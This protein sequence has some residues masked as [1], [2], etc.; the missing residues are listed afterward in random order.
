MKLTF[1]PFFKLEYAFLSFTGVKGTV[2]SEPRA[3]RDALV[4]VKS[5]IESVAFAVL[6]CVFF[7]V[8]VRM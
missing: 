3:E 4:I 2:Y 7:T 5:Q 8:V 1:F 6:Q